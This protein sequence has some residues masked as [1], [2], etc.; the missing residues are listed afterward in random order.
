M[1]M[2]EGENGRIV[3]DLPVGLTDSAED[4]GD[5]SHLDIGRSM[6]NKLKY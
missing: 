4:T 1:E 3:R 2:F 5:G 6:W